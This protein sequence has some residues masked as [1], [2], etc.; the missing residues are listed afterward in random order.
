[1][2]FQLINVLLSRNNNI[3]VNK[4][5]TFQLFIVYYF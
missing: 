2:G 4:L 3:L 5:M 1:M